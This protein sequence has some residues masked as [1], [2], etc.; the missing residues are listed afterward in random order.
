MDEGT[1]I[2]MNNLIRQMLPTTTVLSIIHRLSGLDTFDLIIEMSNG[3]VHKC[4]PP[5][6]FQNLRDSEHFTS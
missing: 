5:D 4:G 2:L 6:M 1:H 3:T